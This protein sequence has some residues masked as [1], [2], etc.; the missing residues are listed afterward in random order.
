SFIEKI[1]SH[2]SFTDLL[3]RRDDTRE[4]LIRTF[5][6]SVY[7]TRL[8]LGLENLEAI[9]EFPDVRT[10]FRVLQEHLIPALSSG[11]PLK[12]V[13]EF[14]A[15]EELK[16]GM[17]FLN[18]GKDTYKVM[19][20]LSSLADVVVR[21][22]VRLLQAEKGFAVIALGGYGAGELNFTSDLDL[23]FVHT[24]ADQSAS[25]S[26][27]P[28]EHLFAKELIRILTEYTDSGVAYKVD[29]RL[30]P[31]GSKGVLMNDIMGYAS[32][33]LKSAQPWEIQSLLR[34]RAV[35]GDKKLL[36][37]FSELRRT[38]IQQRR[39]EITGSLIKSM[40]QRIVRELSREHKGLDV[41]LGP[42]GIKEI[43][44]IVQYLQ[45]KYAD[46][47]PDLILQNTVAALKD[48]IRHRL[49]DK[50]TSDILLQSHRFLRTVEVLL[51]LNGE[52]V[53][54]TNSEIPDI[55][56]ELLD[57]K[58][59]D[60]LFGKIEGIRQQLSQITGVLYH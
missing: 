46:I 47:Y 2:E 23:L 60:E 49:I 37:A 25:D 13:R 30:R 31:D 41:K 45:M 7:L 48:I 52:D 33:Y 21:S 42:G 51:R 22:V 34:A 53:L 6:S 55:I 28:K 17:L 18:R 40:R 36:A 39:R 20:A 38:V 58:S 12:I 9:F 44:F 43:E 19:S 35:A 50:T 29:M 16:T 8:L 5:S 56:I 11:D 10:D 57:L 54:K 1:G 27:G 3:Q 14:K 15:A 4:V 24:P 32:Y 26:D 59:K